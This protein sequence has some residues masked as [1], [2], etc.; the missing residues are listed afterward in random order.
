MCFT[1]TDLY[2]YTV[3]SCICQNENIQQCPHLGPEVGRGEEAG[4]SVPYE[5]QLV[6]GHDEALSPGNE[7]AR[8]LVA[9]HTAVQHVDGIREAGQVR[10]T[11][12]GVEGQQL[13]VL[14]GERHRHGRG[15][16]Q[17]EGGGA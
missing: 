10:Q 12:R 5:H 9:L 11:L 1:K 4:Q 7:D 15:R 3:Y 13:R 14:Q 16:A 6:G 8:R 2:I 17:L